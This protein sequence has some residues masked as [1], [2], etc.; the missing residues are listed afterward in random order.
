MGEKFGEIGE[1]AKLQVIRQLKPAKFLKIVCHPVNQ[2]ISVRRPVN[3]RHLP[4]F[5]SPKL[6]DALFASLFPHQTFPLYGSKQLSE[7]LQSS[8]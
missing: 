3:H 6:L 5:S 2:E 1:L 4:N 8:K 7:L